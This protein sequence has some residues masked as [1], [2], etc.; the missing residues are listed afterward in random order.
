MYP[1][2]G[3]LGRE[4][5]SRLGCSLGGVFYNKTR[6]FPC[7]GADPLPKVPFSIRTAGSRNLQVPAPRNSRSHPPDMAGSMNISTGLANETA[8]PSQR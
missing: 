3:G 2:V 6:T 5:R 1:W 8:V 4:T 7:L